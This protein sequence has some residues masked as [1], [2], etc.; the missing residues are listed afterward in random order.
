MRA[1][2]AAEALSAWERGSERGQVERSLELFALARPGVPL[3]ELADV[4]LGERDGA[5]IDLR[6]AMFGP[7]VTGRLSCTRCGE[8][9]EINLDLGAM[10]VTGSGADAFDLAVDDYAL[11]LR[12][13]SS[14]D[15]LAAAAEAGEARRAL[16]LESC[17]LSATHN[18]GAAEA[19][20]LPAAV[21]DGI[22]GA[23]GRADPQADLQLTVR[24]E[25][26]GH[27]TRMAFDISSFLWEEVD[28]WTGRLLREIHAL[29]SLYG[30]SERDILALS[31]A[32]RRRYMELAGA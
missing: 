13:L 18:G 16:L 3:E 9:Q 11:R 1:P 26:C 29:A 27:A 24:C 30:W 17:V 2:S 8:M 31:P 21:V 4:S 6:E 14:R 20:D 15:M 5:L 10:R 25:T 12:L 7:E 32:R 28:A 22:A 19:R 23:L